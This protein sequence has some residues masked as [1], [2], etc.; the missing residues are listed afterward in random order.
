MANGNDGMK[1]PTLQ[2]VENPEAME[3]T[4][5]QLFEV[6]KELMGDDATPDVLEMPEVREKLQA[7]FEKKEAERRAKAELE[8]QKMLKDKADA[9]IKKANAVLNP[10]KPKPPVEQ[11]RKE[12]L[13]TLLPTKESSEEDRLEK[14]RAR[15]GT[16]YPSCVFE[17]S[18]RAIA[19]YYAL[20]EVVK[21]FRKDLR[22]AKPDFQPILKG[23]CDALQHAIDRVKEII[24]V[25]Y[26]LNSHDLT[27]Y[28][29]SP[30]DDRAILALFSTDSRLLELCKVPETNEQRAL[31][32]QNEAK[33]KAEADAK[34]NEEE[35]ER[36]K[37]VEAIVNLMMTIDH[38]TKLGRAQTLTIARRVAGKFSGSTP[39]SKLKQAAREKCGGNVKTEN[40]HLGIALA[41]AAKCSEDEVRG[42][43]PSLKEKKQKKGN[44]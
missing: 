42:M 26:G 44:K 6:A 7:I 25:G 28:C 14:L 22:K 43:F 10:V 41:R 35:A 34:R 36:M 1:S 17:S 2:L 30:N 33:L 40:R 16:K 5:E 18:G 39:E 13:A 3:P 21:S 32:E 38:F 8:R 27:R 12:K 4:D 15:Y 29:C 9:L 31:R 23:K 11:L 20:I 37:M 19:F 24:E